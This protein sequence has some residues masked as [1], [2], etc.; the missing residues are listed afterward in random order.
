MNPELVKTWSE[1]AL[2]AR[3]YDEL[4]NIENSKG[5]IALVQNEIKRRESETTLQS[6]DARS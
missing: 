4:I 2:K 5:I 1:N 3:I 6:G